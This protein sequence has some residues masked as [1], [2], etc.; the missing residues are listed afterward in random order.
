MKRKQTFFRLC[1]RFCH[2]FRLATLFFSLS[3]ALF[4]DMSEE[5]SVRKRNLS[6]VCVSQVLLSQ[7]CNS[8]RQ[9]GRTAQRLAAPQRWHHH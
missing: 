2:L 1:N 9:D 6:P 4:I 3:V 5:E 8:T 7:M